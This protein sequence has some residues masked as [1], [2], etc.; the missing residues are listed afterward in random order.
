MLQDTSPPERFGPLKTNQGFVWGDVR[1][2]SCSGVDQT[3][4]L[5]SARFASE[6]KPGALIWC[7][8]AKWKKIWTRDKKRSKERCV[9]VKRKQNR[10]T[11]GQ[12]QTRMSLG[13][14]WSNVREVKTKIKIWSDDDQYLVQANHINRRKPQP[15]YIWCL[16]LHYL[17][18]P[19]E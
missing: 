14:T 16:M 8:K 17:F 11:C 15:T 5:R 18:V 6:Q 2:L 3:S 7:M 19:L 4:K 13:Q 12:K 1:A 10:C 9:V